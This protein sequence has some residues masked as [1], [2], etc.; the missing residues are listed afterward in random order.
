MRMTISTGIVADRPTKNGTVYSREA[1]ERVIATFKG[2]KPGG[3]LNRKAIEC[4]D[5]ITH[6]VLA[7]TM[8]L[9]GQLQAEVEIVDS[10]LMEWIRRGRAFN[11]KPI[12]V[13]DLNNPLKIREIRRIDLEETSSS[14]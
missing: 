4:R 1:L 5:R 14:L 2:P 12:V 3:I 13:T 8:P 10:D 11:A 6:N 7:L 9:D